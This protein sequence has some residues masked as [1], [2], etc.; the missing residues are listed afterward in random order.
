MEWGGGVGWVRV[1]GGLGIAFETHEEDVQKE[2]TLKH[3]AARPDR[4]KKKSVK[5]RFERKKRV[6]N[7]MLVPILLVFAVFPFASRVPRITILNCV[8]RGRCT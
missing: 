3:P 7:D 5:R 4:R 6:K 8:M 2:N 1:S